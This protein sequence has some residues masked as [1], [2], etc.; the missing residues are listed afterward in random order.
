MK[1]AII[2]SLITAALAFIFCL[3]V[4]LIIPEFKI[5]HCIGTSIG[6]FIVMFLDTLINKL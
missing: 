5:G 3:L 1:K 4:N 2:V 6:V